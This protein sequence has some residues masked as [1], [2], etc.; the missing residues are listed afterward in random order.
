MDTHG[1][2]GTTDI[3]DRITTFAVAMVILAFV[4]FAFLGLFYLFVLWWRSKKREEASLDYILL[5]VAV[6]RDNEVKIDAAEQM[7]TS[8]HSIKKGGF[9]SF[10]SPPD[11]LSFEIV[12]FPQEI[13]F[14]VS[15]P[16]HLR[17]LV[18]KQIN[19]AYPGADVREVEEYNIFSE[20][21]KVAFTS[22]S[23]GDSDYKPIRL[24]R[25]L[26]TDPLSSIT[27]VLAKMGQG[28]G[29]AVQILITPS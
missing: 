14:Y 15:C 16:I 19:G 17:D 5:Q 13:R 10:L 26:P 12:G 7:F 24:Y 20:E 2:F 9:F 3:I 29:A 6:P 4:F 28:E 8:F 18:E 11:H 21:G 1:I 22:L 25:D 27:S 23:L